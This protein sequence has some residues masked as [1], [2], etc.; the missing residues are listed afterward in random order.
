MV[1]SHDTEPT[2]KAIASLYRLKEDSIGKS[3]CPKLYRLTYQNLEE[4]MPRWLLL[5]IQTMQC[6][7]Q[8][9]WLR[10][11][12]INW[13]CWCSRW[14]T[15]W[16]TDRCI[17]WQSKWLRTSSV[18]ESTLDK[19]HNAICYHRVECVKLL[20]LTQSGLLKKTQRRIWLTCLQRL[21]PIQQA[22]TQSATKILI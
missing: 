4:T 2:M 19:T 10:L 13:E 21:R 1:V 11:W 17:M 14:Y 22:F 18:P 6:G 15:D 3:M 16:P 9:R 5:W 8:Q 20:Q 12:N 7:W